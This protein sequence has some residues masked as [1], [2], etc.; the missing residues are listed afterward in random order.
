VDEQKR[1]RDAQTGGV[2]LQQGKV[3]VMP[4]DEDGAPLIDPGAQ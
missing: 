1:R 3:H 2:L 4:L